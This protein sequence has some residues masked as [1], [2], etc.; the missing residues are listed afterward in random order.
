MPCGAPHVSAIRRYAYTLFLLH[1]H[2]VRA[3][4]ILVAFDDW[5]AFV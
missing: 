3:Q 4:D 5:G 1:E 2:E